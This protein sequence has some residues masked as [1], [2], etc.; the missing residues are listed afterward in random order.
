MKE[1]PI[2]HLGPVEPEPINWR[3]V[4]SSDEDVDDE[5][6]DKTPAE[7]VA[8]LGFDPKVRP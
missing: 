3:A 6:L 4:S 7:I 8:I 5:E 2:I 1:T